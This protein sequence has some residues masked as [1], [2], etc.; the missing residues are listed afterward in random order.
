MTKY[1]VLVK[2]DGQLV[3]YRILYLG[4]IHIEGGK[5]IPSFKACFWL[6]ACN[7]TTVTAADKASLERMSLNFNKGFFK[8]QNKLL[9]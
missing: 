8:I 9:H 7:R 6:L 1:L 4:H 3:Q 2:T 5:K